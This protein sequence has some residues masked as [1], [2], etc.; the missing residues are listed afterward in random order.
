MVVGG[1][2]FDGLAQLGGVDRL[3][4]AAPSVQRGQRRGT[5]QA[6][7]VRREDP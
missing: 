5:R 7:G 2:L 6:P 3:T 4:P 1:C